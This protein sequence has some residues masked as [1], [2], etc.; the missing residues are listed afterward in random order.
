MHNPQHTPGP[1]EIRRSGN[2]AK[3]ISIFIEGVASSSGF[4]AQ[5]PHRDG[6]EL[7][8]LSNASLLAAA[9]EMLF[10]D[11]AIRKAEGRAS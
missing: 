10:I 1:W 7:I 4:I 2:Q 5:L 6:R 11:A 3:D 9:P 8:Q